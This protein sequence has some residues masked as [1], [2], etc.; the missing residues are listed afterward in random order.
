[1]GYEKN[2]LG[3][4]KG[5]GGKNLFTVVARILNAFEYRTF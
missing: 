5:E 4:V 2:F 1:M 3:A